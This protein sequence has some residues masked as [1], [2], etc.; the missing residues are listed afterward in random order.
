M[1][2]VRNR[3]LAIAMMVWF[4]SGINLTAQIDFREIVEE[5]EWVSAIEDA[6]ESD[7]LIFLDIYATWCGPC[8][9]LDKNVYTNLALGEFYNANYINLKM[10][11]ET[12][13]GSSLARKYQL[14]A[15][16]TMF[17]INAEE[18]IITRI[19]G[20][21]EADPLS[22]IGRVISQNH[23]RFQYFDENFSSG[24]LTVDELKEYQRLL[25]AMEQSE[26]A[27]EVAAKIIPSLGKQEILSEEYKDLVINSA[28]D[29]DSEVFKLVHENR[30]I[31][32]SLW[33]SQEKDRFYAGVYNT[34]LFRAI[35]KRDEKLLKRIINEFLPAYM[36]EGSEDLQ[37]GE[38]ITKKLYFANTN[39]WDRYDELVLSLYSQRFEGDDKFLYMEAYEVANEYNQAPGALNMAKKWMETATGINPSFDNLVMISYLNILTG[40]SD[41]ATEYYNQMKAMEINEDQQKVL[42]EIQKML[43]QSATG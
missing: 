18:E 43:D 32:D 16:P 10:D 6:R 15:Y 7:K 23:S 24:N 36:G 35:D 31:I 29:M 37:Q 20:V 28:S 1:K 5:E 27:E 26:K 21:R 4:F 3:V 41:K 12:P 11:G 14:S 9:Y 19:V 39:S 13:F 25:A 30:E 22:E 40:N 34:T 33:T 2:K 17:Y 38:F 8:K 42:D